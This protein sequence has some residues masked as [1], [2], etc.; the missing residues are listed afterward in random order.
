[1]IVSLA[2]NKNAWYN[3]PMKRSIKIFIVALFTLLSVN[4]FSKED[5]KADE[6]NCEPQKEESTAS[7]KAKKAGKTVKKG[8]TSA[9]KTVGSFF[10]GVFSSDDD[11]KSDDK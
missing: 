9:A 6:K 5:E 10:Q 1:M 11:E 4:L 7:E 3:I 2:S 8:V